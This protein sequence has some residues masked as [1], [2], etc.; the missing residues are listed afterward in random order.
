MSD[1]NN[2][3]VFQVSVPANASGYAP[4]SLPNESGSLPGSIL[5]QIWSIL[6]IWRLLVLLLLVGNVKNI[7]L[8]WHASIQSNENVYIY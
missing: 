4:S 3:I 7:P 2:S 1:F 5:S 8:I 6:T